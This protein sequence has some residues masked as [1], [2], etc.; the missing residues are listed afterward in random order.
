MCRG[1][2]AGLRSLEIRDR[3]EIGPSSLL[4]YGSSC[5]LVRF[6]LG[7]DC[8]NFFSVDRLAK[9]DLDQTRLGEQTGQEF[10]TSAESWRWSAEAEVPNCQPVKTWERI[11]LI[12]LT[13]LPYSCA[14]L[15]GS[16]IR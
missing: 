3:S 1:T 7:A 11:Q 13:I 10:F 12:T 16:V 14:P 4:L 5:L 2:P 8:R 9:S 6:L 15:G